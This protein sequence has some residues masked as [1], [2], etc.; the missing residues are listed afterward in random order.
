LKQPLRADRFGKGLK[1]TGDNLR[2][3]TFEKLHEDES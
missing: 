3:L 2:V 1:K